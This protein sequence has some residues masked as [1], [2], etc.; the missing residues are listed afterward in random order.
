MAR[1]SEEKQKRIQ[2]VVL[3]Q[4]AR[5]RVRARTRTIQFVA[6]LICG[7]GLLYLGL[8]GGQTS[9]TAGGGAVVLYALFMRVYVRRPR[10]VMEEL[11]REIARVMKTMD[12]DDVGAAEPSAD[13]NEPPA[14]DGK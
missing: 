1:V 14:G 8:S 12:A 5:M 3:E 10:Y 9:V 6:L 7:G 4:G 2:Q 11:R 13:E